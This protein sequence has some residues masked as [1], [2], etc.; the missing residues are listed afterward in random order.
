MNSS[1]YALGID[2][3]GTKIAIGVVAADG[4]VLGGAF[5]P[6]PACDAPSDART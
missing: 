3:G 2:I 5:L 6:D 1:D 4:R